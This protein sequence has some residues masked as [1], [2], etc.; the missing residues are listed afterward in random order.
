MLVGKHS[1]PI[2]S[3]IVHFVCLD[4]DDCVTSHVNS[5]QIFTD[6]FYGSQHVPRISGIIG[7][8]GISPHHI[9]AMVELVI[10]LN[11]LSH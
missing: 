3:K 1:S 10:D 2:I 8:H 5:G 11:S 9:Q 4:I 6:V 7:K